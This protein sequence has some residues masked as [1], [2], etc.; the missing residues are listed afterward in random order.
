MSI[1]VSPLIDRGQFRACFNGG[2]AIMFFSILATTWCRNFEDLLLVQGVLTGIGMG[3][4]FGSGI[5]V[6]RSYFDT[7]LGIA[8][9]LTSAGGSVGMFAP[10]S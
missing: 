1:L 6:L 8:A 3:V 2:C 10:L 7:H 5:L 9:G 4:A